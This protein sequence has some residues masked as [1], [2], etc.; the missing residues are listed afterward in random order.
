M[1][2][3]VRQNLLNQHNLVLQSINAN[4]KEEFG[5]LGVHLLNLLECEVI[6][7]NNLVARGLVV[8]FLVAHH[9]SVRG[10]SDHSAKLSIDRLALKSISSLKETQDITEEHPADPLS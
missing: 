3:S 4:L 8:D 9:I 5:S 2:A 6:T 7:K 1:P 10:L